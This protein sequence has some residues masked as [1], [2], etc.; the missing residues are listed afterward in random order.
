MEIWGLSVIVITMFR[1][2]T[3]IVISITVT[4]LMEHLDEN[5]S[6]LGLNKLSQSMPDNVQG[7]PSCKHSNYK[8]SI[9]NKV[10]IK[11]KN[12]FRNI[13]EKG[14]KKE[15]VFGVSYWGYLTYLGGSQYEY[16]GYQ[17]E[18]CVYLSLNITK[19]NGHHENKNIFYSTH[20]PSN[21]TVRRYIFPGEL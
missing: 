20:S 5:W 7:G 14:I 13:S 15:E 17:A 1:M 18:L 10:H 9:H 2:V 19:H 6:Q 21:M 12:T 4:S 16:G 3:M 11:I 8:T